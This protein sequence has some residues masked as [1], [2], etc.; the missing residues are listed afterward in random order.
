MDFLSPF[1]S[2]SL[3]SDKRSSSGSTSI[4]K[5]TKASTA[6]INEAEDKTIVFTTVQSLFNEINH[7]TGDSLTVI[8]VSRS[9]LAAIK[10]QRDKLNQKLRFWYQMKYHLL[11][12]TIPTGVHEDLHIRLY[13][14]VQSGLDT[15]G[16]YN[17]AW[18]NFGATRCDGLA[19][20]GT[21]GDEGEGDSSGGPAPLRSPHDAWPTIVFE[22]AYTRTLAELRLKKDWWFRASNHDV[23]IVVLIQFYSEG[24]ILIER[25]EEIR[26]MIQPR[27]GATTTRAAAAQNA[28]AI[29]PILQQEIR[30]IRDNTTNPPSYNVVRNDL[31][32]SFRL[33][34]LRDPGP[35]EHDIIIDVNSLIDYADMAWARARP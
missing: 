27:Q 4:S 1:D 20:T 25:W 21:G 33:L 29:S 2:A 31:V 14:Y 30:I 34:F 11:I 22:S 24:I 35:N 17:R 12:I 16:L 18:H 10:A 15:M 28:S 5:S 23:K 26:Q 7:T 32:L 6:G 13:F 8:N 19:N 3:P 9:D